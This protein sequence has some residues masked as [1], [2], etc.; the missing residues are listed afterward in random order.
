VFRKT[1]V[2][3][4]DPQDNEIFDDKPTSVVWAMGRLA[5]VFYFLK[6]DIEGI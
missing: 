1:L 2:P 3:S 6:M 5:Q 4:S